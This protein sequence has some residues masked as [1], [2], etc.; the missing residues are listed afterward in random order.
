MR[1]E[2]PDI[3]TL[4]APLSPG[5]PRLTR[6]CSIRAEIG[7]ATEFDTSRGTGR[8]MFPIT[9]GA[10]AASDW[11]ATILP[12]GADFARRLA[13][14]TYEIEARYFLELEDGTV[15]MVHNAGRMVPQADGSFHGRTRA[16]LEVPPGPHAA[17]ADMVLFGTAYA[18]ADDEG[19][20]FIELWHAAV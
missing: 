4:G 5:Q 16:E 20:V 9:G 18:P 14:G 10:A 3:T 19:N 17:L 1:G 15:V 2:C 11:R 6:V 7:P 8:A 12:G 13:D